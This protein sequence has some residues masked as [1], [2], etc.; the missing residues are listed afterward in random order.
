MLIRNLLF[1]YLNLHVDWNMILNLCDIQVH[2]ISYIY[3]YIFIICIITNNIWVYQTRN[4]KTQVQLSRLDTQ[5]RE[6]IAR[7]PLPVWCRIS[8]NSNSI[9]F[10]IYLR[11]VQ[12]SNSPLPTSMDF[13]ITWRKRCKSVMSLERQKCSLVWG[14]SSM[15]LSSASSRPLPISKLKNNKDYQNN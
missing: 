10:L 12:P 8:P 2:F 15:S 3:R 5:V 9:S 14:S 6:R 4:Q 7:H 13:S 11:N 1:I